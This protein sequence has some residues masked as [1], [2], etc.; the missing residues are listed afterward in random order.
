MQPTWIKVNYVA[1]R[2]TRTMGNSWG[3]TSRVVASGTLAEA[4][5]EALKVAEMNNITDLQIK[6]GGYPWKAL[7]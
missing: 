3:A 4:K 6:I 7:N 2:Y 5:A 1:G